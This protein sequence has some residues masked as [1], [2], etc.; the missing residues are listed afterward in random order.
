MSYHDKSL[1]CSDCTRLFAFS[2]EDQGL[3]AELG[4]AQPVRCGVCRSSRETSRR[5]SGRD[6]AFTWR[7]ARIIP[8]LP[9]TVAEPLALT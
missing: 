4:Y 1:T 9:L 5:Q 2:A 6:A 8:A 3:S 7:I